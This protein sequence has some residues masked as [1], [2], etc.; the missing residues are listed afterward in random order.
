LEY[1]ADVNAALPHEKEE[2]F[3]DLV[4]KTWGITT[5]FNYV[6]PE[7]IADLELILYEKIRQKTF[8]QND[9]GKTVKKAFH[10][11]DLED[12][13][14][15]TQDQFTK[16][17]DKFGCVFNQWEIQALFKK[18]DKDNLGKL[19]YDEFCALFATMGSGLNP[20]VNPVFQLSREA[21]YDILTLIVK[22]Q[23]KKGIFA[24]RNLSVIMRKLDKTKSGKVKRSE[25]TW[26][27]KEA[28]QNLT[29]HDLDKLFKYFD[30]Q[31]E[32]NVRYDEF[33]KY[34]NGCM[35]EARREIVQSLFKSLSN[36]KDTVC[37]ETL[38]SSYHPSGNPDVK[39]G[40]RKAD[41]DKKEFLS[42]WDNVRKD[43]SIPYP[44]FEDYFNDISAAVD[45]DDLF[46][47]IIKNSFGQGQ[48]IE[49][50]PSPTKHNGQHIETISSPT[51][52]L[53][54]PNLNNT[55]DAMRKTDKLRV[56]FADEKKNH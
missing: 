46:Y 21:P 32:D 42:L 1:Y 6:S 24:Y 51:I 23:K 16:A 35:G 29:K 7:R 19:P 38:K 30:K 54:Q 40:K 17:L 3:V 34:V 39:S 48:Q 47:A 9:E 41:D 5:S 43:G 28:G 25:F 53:E 50:I 31:C 8:G 26:G 12:K 10:Y 15:I 4:L 20:N 27:I 2:Y 14:V 56:S 36:G 13:G 22:E 11:F 18:Y 33:L 44:D 49:T 45:S 37:L 55:Q 52:Q